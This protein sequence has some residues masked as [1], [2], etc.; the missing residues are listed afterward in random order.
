MTEWR[1]IPSW[2]AYEASDDGRIRRVGFDRA[3]TL[4]NLHGYH[5]VWLSTT[6]RKG[7]NRRAHRLVCE[8]FRGAPPLP[9]M[10]VAHSN[11]IKTDNRPANLRWATRAENERDKKSHGVSNAG[12]RNGMAK[13]SEPDVREIRRRAHAAP[14]GMRKATA[15]RISE[16]FG[17]GVRTVYGIV[18]GA[19]WGHLPASTEAEAAHE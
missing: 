13:L 5:V 3:L 8:A 4:V 15:T 6:P 16:E 17:I 19:Y 14:F 10:D 11:G 2:P 12:T 7:K 18:S 1:Q 9:G